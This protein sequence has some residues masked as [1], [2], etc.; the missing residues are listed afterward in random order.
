MREE[1]YPLA[2]L[3]PAYHNGLPDL[4]RVEGVDGLAG[5]EHDV[6]GGIHDGVYGTHAGGVDPAAQLQR[7]LAS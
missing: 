3:R 1:R 4:S 2:W 6:I 7:R 5:L